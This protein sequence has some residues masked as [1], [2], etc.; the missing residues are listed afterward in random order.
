VRA[1]FI[2]VGLNFEGREAPLK[3]LSKTFDTA[4]DWARYAPN[5]WIL[6]TDVSLENWLNRIRKVVHK[7]DSVFLVELNLDN[8][9]GLLPREIWDWINKERT[10]Q[11]T[12]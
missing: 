3:L 12:S 9:R 1:K 6:Y 2:H 10:D 11:S 5:C 8:R 4:L 7:E